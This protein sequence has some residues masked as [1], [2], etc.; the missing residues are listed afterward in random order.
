[1]WADLEEFDNLIDRKFA[2]TVP[3]DHL[4]DELYGVRH[5]EC[6]LDSFPHTFSGTLS[7]SALP[8]TNLPVCE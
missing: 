3:T 8:I 5:R 1:M 7:P 6:T 2:I 4:W